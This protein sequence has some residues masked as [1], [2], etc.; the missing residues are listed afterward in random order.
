MCA[1][2][3]THREKKIVA[4]NRDIN[5]K[6]KAVAAECGYEALNA[7]SSPTKFLEAFKRA[8]APSPGVLTQRA[9]LAQQSVDEF[10]SLLNS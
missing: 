4:E 3:I 8:K 5:S 7:E 1:I 6:L 10:I 2:N 9:Y